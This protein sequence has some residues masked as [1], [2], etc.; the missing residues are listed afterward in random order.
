[1][2]LLTV[3][4][5]PPEIFANVL[6]HLDL[7]S[8]IRIRCVNWTWRHIPLNELDPIR[9]ALYQLYLAAISG[10]GLQ[11]A[12]TWI[13]E[14]LEP[15]DRA[16]H[17]SQ[18]RWQLGDLS[19][20]EEFR[21]WLCEWPA[22]A[23]IAFMWPGLPGSHKEEYGLLRRT[24]F[25]YLATFPPQ[26]YE[27]L[28]ELGPLPGDIDLPIQHTH[29]ILPI[30][31][32]TYN[33]PSTYIILGDCAYVRGKVVRTP[34]GNFYINVDDF[35]NPPPPGP[36]TAHD[37]PVLDGLDPIVLDASRANRPPSDKGCQILPWSGTAIYSGWIYYLWDCLESMNSGSYKDDDFY[38][39]SFRQGEPYREQTPGYLER[40]FIEWKG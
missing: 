19:M 11:R 28:I 38:A 8:L 32:G 17:L 31:G 40:T 6:S 22:K 23:A 37:K 24:G 18:I 3:L 35:Q 39:Y 12:K 36:C 30:W 13:E 29:P 26:L 25:N 14:H 21:V 4:D 33:Q 5:L 2:G 9:L 16:A 1:M 27:C 10:S 20:P 7:V 34:D 15:F